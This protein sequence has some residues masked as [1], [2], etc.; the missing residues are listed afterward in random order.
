VADI[1]NQNICLLQFLL[2]MWTGSIS[3]NMVH[4]EV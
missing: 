1:G 3:G 4:R 2:H